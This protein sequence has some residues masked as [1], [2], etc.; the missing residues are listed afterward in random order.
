MEKKYKIIQ[1]L[2]GLDQGGAES[3]IRD[4]ALELSK[5]GHQVE[6]PLFYTTPNLPNQM[7][8]EKA[9]IRI[10]VFRGLYS[11]SLIHI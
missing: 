4:Y 3:V 6:I 5:R 10:D 2:G 9:E 8:L 11:L 1:F 7:A